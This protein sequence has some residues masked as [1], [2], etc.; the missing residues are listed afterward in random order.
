MCP[1]RTVSEIW[2]VICRNSP[3]FTYPTY[4]W[5]PRLRGDS[6]GIS[7]RSFASEKWSPELSCVCVIMCLAVLTQYRLV[8]DK[9]TDGRT[10]R[11]R[12]RQT[13][14]VPLHISRDQSSHGK[15][16][17]FEYFPPIGCFSSI[18]LPL[19]NKMWILCLKPAFGARKLFYRAMLCIRGTSHGF[20]SVCLSV[21]VCPSVT[22]R[23]STKTAKRRIKQTTTR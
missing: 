20:V 10:E 21:S 6:I 4:S 8:T 12:D 13:D 11:Q 22:S 19:P 9:Q 23:C 18:K 1:S 15:N 17:V 2:W 5:R 3:I 16:P 7:P 14:T